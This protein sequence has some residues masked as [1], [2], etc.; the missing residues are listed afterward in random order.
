M[1]WKKKPMLLK[2]LL[3]KWLLPKFISK[4]CPS[5][6]SRSGEK[7]KSVNCYYVK[8]DN[9]DSTQFFV[10]TDYNCGKLLGFKWD[11]DSYKDEHRLELADLETGKLRITHIYGLDEIGYDSIYS[12]TWY[13]L[14]KFDHLYFDINQYIYSVVFSVNQYF[15][16]KKILIPKKRMELLKFMLNEQLKCTHNGIELTELMT[17]LHTIKFWGHPSREEYE[18]TLEFCLDSLVCTDDLRITGNQQYVVTGQAIATIEKYENE[19]K[20][21]SEIVKLQIILIV[22]TTLLVFVGLVQAGVGLVQAT[23]I[24]LPTLFDL[25]K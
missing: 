19:E 16:N 7:G 6:I 3:Y 20:K 2:K 4:A 23:V 9:M 1:Q 22:V 21:H 10:A 14:T 8:L 11:G 12:A 25:S 24:N 13:Y 5:R 15:F 18:K 17:K